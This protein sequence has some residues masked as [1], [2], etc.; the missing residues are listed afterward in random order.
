MT[1]LNR[2]QPS[3]AF[4]GRVIGDSGFAS[5]AA[6]HEKFLRGTG[7]AR[8]ILRFVEARGIDCRRR[9]L[10][11]ADFTGSDLRGAQFAGCH[12]ERAA[13][14]CTDLGGA[15]LRST[16][17]KRADLR[18]A[19]LAGAALNGAV[20]DE[21][22]MR[23]AYIAMTDASGSL[24]IV[25]RRLGRLLGG[26]SDS[27]I[28]ADF[29]NC[30]MRGVRLCA[31]NL[32]GANFTGAVL[33]AADFTG[34]KLDGAVFHDAVLTG[35]TGVEPVLS[36]QQRGSC[37]FDATAQAVARAP[38]LLAALQVAVEWGDTRGK[39]GAP[40]VLDNE[41]L[42]PLSTAFR[43]RRSPALSAK[44]ARAI[45]LDF[46]G[47]QFQGAI[48]DGADLR[49]AVFE[50]ADLR[51]ASFRDAKLS[52]AR[53]SRADL[54]PLAGANGKLYPP[55]FEGASLDRVDFSHTALEGVERQT[56]PTS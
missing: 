14:H 27:D 30:A 25:P 47:G 19:V 5:I 20:L 42:R 28:G 17:L 44:G 21:A 34:A 53:F 43:G 13:L 49:G 54:R 16:N 1:M 26:L 22:D 45:G 7:G 55:N 6:A 15:D 51:G 24:R 36:Q 56:G 12:F 4:A 52:H 11:D 40:A 3:L 9:I 2:N 37:V 38:A 33:D 29:T 46:S 10:N 41:D 18:G 35:L 50:E 48:F 39:Q 23:A 31:A 32:K 8:A